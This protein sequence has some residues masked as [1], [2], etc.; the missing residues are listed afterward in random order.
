MCIGG[1]ANASHRG[2][3][4]H[5]T[6]KVKNVSFP[7]GRNLK[8]T[9]RLFSCAAE[10]QKDETSRNHQF[11]NKHTDCFIK[12]CGDAPGGKAAELLMVLVSASCLGR[13]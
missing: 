12:P 4:E 3:P 11:S 9:V 7:A 8:G 13:R 5:S 10:S 2:D 1:S 6:K